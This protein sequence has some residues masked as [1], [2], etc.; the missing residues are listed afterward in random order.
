MNTR[1]WMT[2]ALLPALAAPVV[3]ALPP[4]VEQAF[5]RYMAIPA[6]LLPVLEKVKDKATADA[7]APQLQEALAAVYDARDA[8]KEIKELSE[9]DAAE[10]KARYE[11][12]MREEWGRLYR[13][14]F[15]LQQAK[16]YNSEEFFKLF[17]Y[18]CLMLEK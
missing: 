7:A 6:A 2:A 15:R 8:L 14:I 18:M 12:R 11:K 16:C 9:A 10:V 17:S 5:E 13:E 4:A 3:L 1:T